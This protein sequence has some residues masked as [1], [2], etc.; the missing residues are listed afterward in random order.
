MRIFLLGFMGSGKTTLGK[1][2][3]DS[4]NLPFF[5]LDQE[6]EKRHKLS[7]QE[8]F[9]NHGEFYFR[10]IESDML[11]ELVEEN[12]AFI[13]ACGGGTPCFN[14]NMAKLNSS[15]VTIFLDVEKQ[16]LFDRLLS[17]KSR[18]PLIAALNDK[19]LKIY[20]HQELEKRRIFYLQS[21]WKVTSNNPAI[22][23]LLDLLVY[24]K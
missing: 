11:A 13:L 3:A 9:E 20:I 6:I 17:S 2:L 8:I 7:I 22:T 21:R 19:E 10:Q 14:E 5:D 12:H 16:I 24:S 4:I 15:G 23:E 18:R 1:K